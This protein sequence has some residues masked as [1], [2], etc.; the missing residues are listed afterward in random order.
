MIQS[1]LELLFQK[2]DRRTVGLMSGTSADGLD[3]AYCS[4]NTRQHFVRNL[5]SQAVPYPD[6][7]RRKVLAIARHGNVTLTELI[8]LSGCLGQFYADATGQF[9]LDH[10][11]TT[12]DI[13]LVGSHGQTVAHISKPVRYLDRT[14]S[15]TLQIGEAEFI[16][17]RLGITTVSDFRSGDIALGGSGAPLAPI[18]HQAVFAR[19]GVTN[20]VVNIGGIANITLLKGTE[21]CLATDTGP[22]N[23]L[24]D[25]VISA[26][27]G[28]QFDE[29]GNLA[30]NGDIDQ[31]LLQALLGNEVI[32][33]KPPI[34]HD[35]G[36]ILRLLDVASISTALTQLSTE[37]AAATITELTAMT[38]KHAIEELSGGTVPEAVLV[39][40]G[41]AH[42]RF[43]LNRL[44]VHLANSKVATT[45]AFALNVD[46][47][48]AEAFAYLANLTVDSLCGNMPQVTG[49][50]RAAVLGK[51]SLP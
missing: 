47:V 48:E 28:L 5:A 18:Y 25:S 12:G 29:D 2:T 13:D 21:E 50:S 19:P 35:R 1:S 20:V 8:A 9:C 22:G 4:V 17:K 30:G 14:V 40:G 38:I 24:L 32:R 49:A 15:G 26:R 41:G 44:Q 31:T 36:E 10:K 33:R 6:S 51:I 23:C 43:L 39:C 3:I 42:N 45:A 11:I 27:T 7:L 16:A 34:S 46:F 37:S